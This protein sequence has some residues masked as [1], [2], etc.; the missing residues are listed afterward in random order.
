[1]GSIL[2]FPYSRPS[3]A[4]SSVVTV[5]VRDILLCARYTYNLSWNISWES[6]NRTE[7]ANRCFKMI[8]TVLWSPFGIWHRKIWH[9]YTKCRTTY[10]PKVTS[11]K[12][13]SCYLSRQVS[14]FEI[15][16]Y[17]MSLQ[18]AVS[19]L[20]IYYLNR[21]QLLETNPSRWHKIFYCYREA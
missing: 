7:V 19:V 14:Y 9:K 5:H 18:I 16:N 21:N 13:V 10:L 15:E 11:Q 20:I 8:W 12:K 4:G 2:D 3:A 1:M 6:N 17:N